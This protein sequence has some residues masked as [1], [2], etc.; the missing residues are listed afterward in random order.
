MRSSPTRLRL[1]LLA[2]AML[3]SACA[4]VGRLAIP[5]QSVPHQVAEETK[6]KVWVEIEDGKKVPIE[7]RL[8]E[9]W[10]IASP[11]VVDG[12]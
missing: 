10:W 7:V 8:L 9:G 2:S 3:S 12:P 1:A 11:Q 6:V 5:D 4:S